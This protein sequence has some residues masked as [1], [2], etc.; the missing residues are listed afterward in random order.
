MQTSF[1][2]ASHV[3][4]ETEERAKA[5]RTFKDGMLLLDDND[6]LPKKPNVYVFM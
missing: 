6:L 4:G 3:Y 5:L 1:L 2:D